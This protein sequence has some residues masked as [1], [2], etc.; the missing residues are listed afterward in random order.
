MAPG[1][2]AVEFNKIIRAD[3][4][5]KRK[6]DLADKIFSRRSSASTAGVIGGRKVPAGPSASFGRSAITKVSSGP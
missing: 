6:Q 2:E 4:D 5:K 3:R 1:Q